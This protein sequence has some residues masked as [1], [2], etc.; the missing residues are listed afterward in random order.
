MSP[1]M[2]SRRVQRCHCNQRCVRC[3]DREHLQE[4]W[5]RYHR[6]ETYMSEDLKCSWRARENGDGTYCIKMWLGSSTL[7]TQSLSA[8]VTR[9]TEQFHFSSNNFI[10]FEER[11]CIRETNESFYLLNTSSV[12]DRLAQSVQ[13]KRPFQR[14]TPVLCWAT[15]QI[16]PTQESRF[17]FW[18]CSRQN[19]AQTCNSP[20]IRL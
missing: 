7:T 9:Q 12:L 20:V 13:M 1:E 8:E 5:P 6:L 11:L 3:Y 16:W 14:I 17:V 2:S 15:W 4:W 10:F 18:Q 19:T